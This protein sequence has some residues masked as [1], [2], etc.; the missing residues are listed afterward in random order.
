MTTPLKLYCIS[1][2]AAFLVVGCKKHEDQSSTTS[3]AGAAP[4]VAAAAAT[5]TNESAPSLGGTAPAPAEVEVLPGLD[6]AA[7]ALR[8]KDYIGASLALVK[9]N[10]KDLT[11]DELNN[12]AQAMRNLQRSVAEAAAAGDARAIEAGNILRAASAK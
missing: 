10:P 11:P 12:R 6:S 3:A 1:L 2:A 9:M 4:D 7:T 8:T 5:T